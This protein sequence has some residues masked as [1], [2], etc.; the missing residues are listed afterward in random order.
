MLFFQAT[1]DITK[2]TFKNTLFSALVEPPALLSYLHLV[3]HAWLYH[4]VAISG[5][6]WQHRSRGRPRSPG[7]HRSIRSSGPHRET[8]RPRRVC[9]YLQAL[10]PHSIHSMHGVVYT[11]YLLSTGGHQMYTEFSIVRTADSSFDSEGTPTVTSGAWNQ[12]II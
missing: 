5:W 4:C 2:K 11:R 8:G 6:P 7:L 9:E 1:L 3:L 10:S 12:T